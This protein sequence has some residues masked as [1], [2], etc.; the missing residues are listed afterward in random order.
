MSQNI[1]LEEIKIFWPKG[2]PDINNVQKY[3]SKYENEKIVI[4]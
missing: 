1:S 2:A 4:K 3:V